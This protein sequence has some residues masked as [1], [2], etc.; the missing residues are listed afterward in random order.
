VQ[1]HESGECEV[2]KLEKDMAEKLTAAA[3]DKARALAEAD[4]EI[5][6][7]RA[8]ARALEADLVGKDATINLLEMRVLGL[9]A[10]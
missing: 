1:L 5:R 2:G 8:E 4:L 9:L 10:S 3:Q 6:A 7:T